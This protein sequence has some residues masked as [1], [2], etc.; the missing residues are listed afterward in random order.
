MY[1]PHP[2]IG[3][4]AAGEVWFLIRVKTPFPIRSAATAS[5]RAP[6]RGPRRHHDR[7]DHYG[8]WAWQPLCRFVKHRDVL[9]RIERAFVAVFDHVLNGEDPIGVASGCKK[10]RQKPQ[11]HGTPVQVQRE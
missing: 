6:L 7:I 3:D 1:K 11:N 4:V 2:A 10:P 8:P 5:Q 9:S